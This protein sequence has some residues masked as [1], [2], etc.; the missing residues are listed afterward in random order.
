MRFR[1]QVS[2]RHW[3]ANVRCFEATTALTGLVAHIAQAIHAGFVPCHSDAVARV[4]RETAAAIRRLVAKTR[5]RGYSRFCIPVLK[6]IIDDPPRRE[7]KRDGEHA[8]RKEAHSST[9]GEV[10]IIRA[11]L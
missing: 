1:I 8:L 7:K 6:R 9:V 5:H 2:N 10:A 3:H 4:N 11:R